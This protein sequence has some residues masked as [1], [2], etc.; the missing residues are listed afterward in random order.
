M[1]RLVPRP[2]VL[3]LMSLSFLIAAPGV[4][5]ACEKPTLSVSPNRAAAG[6][7]VIWDTGGSLSSGHPWRLTL[8]GSVIDEGV[9]NGGELGGTFA[10]PDFG[11]SQTVSVELVAWHEAEPWM[12][13]KGIDFIVP[14]PE[15]PPRP[16]DGGQG[17]GGDGARETG[18]RQKEED[19]RERPEVTPPAAAPVSGTATPLPATVPAPIA[20]DRS[21]R[22]TTA[23]RGRNGVER[24]VLDTHLEARTQVGLAHRVVVPSHAERPTTTAKGPTGLEWLMILLIATGLI[25]LHKRHAR[26]PSRPV[27]RTAVIEAELQE[28]IAEERVK[29]AIAPSRRR[30]PTSS[31]KS[32]ART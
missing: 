18:D 22:E 27:R 32:G 30:D 9:I 26:V 16:S 23:T 5:L 29:E 17:G 24:F 8:A 20:S 31:P 28:I 12:A 14:K 6:D 3:T 13:S 11:Q 21:A 15:P 10:M 7:T 4:A 19:S 25:L 1:F 2:V